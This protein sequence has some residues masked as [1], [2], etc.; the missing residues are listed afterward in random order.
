MVGADQLPR[1][2]ELSSNEAFFSLDRFKDLRGKIGY[3][4]VQAG[5]YVVFPGHRN[6]N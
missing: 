2:E 1:Q 5:K 4:T 3:V 6:M